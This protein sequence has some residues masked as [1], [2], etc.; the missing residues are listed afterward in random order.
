MGS[1][2]LT[3]L[4]STLGVATAKRANSF[5][6]R[7]SSAKFICATAACLLG[8]VA[9][10]NE[11]HAQCLKLTTS[12]GKSRLSSVPTSFNGKCPA[13]TIT[14]GAATGAVGTPGAP[15]AQGPMGPQGPQGAQGPAGARGA[16]AFDPIPSG[17]TVY[18]TMGMKQIQFDDYDTFVYA[19]L[20]AP[21][22][23]PIDGEKIIIKANTTLLYNCNAMKC[24]TAR[25]QAGQSFCTGTSEDPKAAPGYICIYPTASGGAM[26]DG[27]LDTY[28]LGWRGGMESRLGFNV[29]YTNAATGVHEFEAVWAYTAP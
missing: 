9:L 29:N 28:L 22:S 19:S 24:L 27:S 6:S 13:G 5:F 15:G 10:A 2:T 12:R 18:G 20:P 1:L 16:S 25:H 4:T 3:G 17:K 23:T 8:S 26:V 7:I 11:S 14:I 21:S